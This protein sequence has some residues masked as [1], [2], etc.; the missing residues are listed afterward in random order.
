MSGKKFVAYF[1]GKFSPDNAPRRLEKAAKERKNSEPE[2][3]R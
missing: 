1:E 3:G 2:M